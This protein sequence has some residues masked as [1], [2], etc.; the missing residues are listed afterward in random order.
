MG[1]PHG[2]DASGVRGA[3][4][5]QPQR[6][7]RRPVF[8]AA[9]TIDSSNTASVNDIVLGIW[10]ARASEAGIAMCGRQRRERDRHYR[11]GRPLTH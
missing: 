6:A 11:R 7:R 8:I 3:G 5:Q 10:S 1:S 4:R 9:F 2:R